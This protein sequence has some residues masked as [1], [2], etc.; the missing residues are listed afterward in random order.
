MKNT[1]Y[2]YDYTG[3]EQTFTAPCNGYYKLEVW[4]A[5]GG[6][7]Q[8]FTGGLGGY[9]YGNYKAIKNQT[10]RI[11]VGQRGGSNLS[12]MTTPSS[13][14][15]AYNGGGAG[16][17]QGGGM[18]DIRTNASLSSQLIVAG[19]G[20]GAYTRGQGF[21]D[22]NGGSG[23]G[24]TGGNGT[25]TNHTLNFGYGYGTGG[26]QTAGGG[27][28][29]INLGGS[30]CSTGMY[31]NSSQWTCDNQCYNIGGTRGQGGCGI[32]YQGGGG[33]GYYGGGGAAH[34][35]AGGGS[36]Y[37]GGVLNGSTISGQR[38]GGGY[39]KITYLGTSI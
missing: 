21:G 20:G 37:I 32:A 1:P 2:A 33:G 5:Q 8:T 27:F 36:G 7:H 14:T 3:G 26:S 9:S 13:A 22:G 23:G 17:G 6:D 24:L 34:G 11:Y 19:G 12:S 4:G 30:A 28:N 38:S 25:S 18:T 29:F 15:N 10:L 39:A 16:G 35:G 31:Y